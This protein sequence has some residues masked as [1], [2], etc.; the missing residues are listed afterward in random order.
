M[1]NKPLGRTGLR[2]S[3]A[4]LGTNAFGRVDEAGSRAIVNA[5]LDAGINFIDTADIYGAG[6][7][8]EYLG[9]SIT[10]RRQHLVI[11]T[12]VRGKMG[13]DPNDEGLSRRHVI[14]GLEASLRR[15]QTDYI[16]LYQMHFPDE[17]TPLQETLRTLDDLVSQGK[18]RY[19]GVSNF[20]AWRM[21]LALWVS[22]THDYV[23]FVCAQEHYSLINREPETEVFP[24]CVD[25][26]VAVIAYSPTGGGF[27]TGKYQR[28]AAAPA[29]TRA[30]RSAEFH[31][32]FTEAN[33]A[34]L[35]RLTAMAKEK[36]CGPHHLA[37]AWVAT[38][39]AVTCPIVGCSN[40][41]QLVDNLKY[42]EV[43][44]TAE[45]RAILSGG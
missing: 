32:R 37:L 35:E 2:V 7:S 24:A 17:A 9:R 41:E 36:D 25:Q 45:E 6:R 11:A 44:L 23:S 19:I 22:D 16:D 10:G 30:A 29:G 3:E 42:L 34:I 40:A 12:K 33:W 4:C 38:N 26:G 27:L 8:E 39:P 31:K 21:M 20:E 43:S 13:H 1:R 28:G 15:L 18:I 5:A 14:D